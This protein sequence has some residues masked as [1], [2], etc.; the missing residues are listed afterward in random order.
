MDLAERSCIGG[1]CCVELRDQVVGS[2]DGTH[3]AQGADDPATEVVDHPAT[4]I[5]DDQRKQIVD[6][7]PHHQ[8][9]ALVR[10]PADRDEERR[11]QTPCD[12]RGNVGHDHARKEC[13]EF[14]DCYSRAPRRDS[15]CTQ[16]LTPVHVHDV[17]VS[18][19]DLAPAP[20]GP[21]LF[22]VAASH[23]ACTAPICRPSN[24]PGHRDPARTDEGGT[25]PVGCVPPSSTA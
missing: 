25:R 6:G 12:Q 14:L 23:M 9:E 21:V 20:T 3:G 11:Q 4:G 16:D 10:Y 5:G 22:T 15:G 18:R 1:Q 8:S 7:G 24:R 17:G 13:P 2:D 19:D